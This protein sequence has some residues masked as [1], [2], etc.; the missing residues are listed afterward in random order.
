VNDSYLDRRRRLLV[1]L[2][3]G[4]PL[5]IPS[6]AGAMGNKPLNPTIYRLK[7]NAKVN[8]QPVSEATLIKL[9][10][11]I[12]TGDNSEMVFIVGKDAFLARGNTQV[13]TS[14]ANGVVKTLRLISGAV[15]SVHAPGEKQI[16]TPVATLGIRGTGVY[17]EA[18]DEKSYFCTCYGHTLIQSNDDP[19]ISKEIKTTHHDEPVWV[20]RR[21]EGVEITKAKMWNHTDAELEML[22][23]TVGREPPFEGH[24]GG[25]RY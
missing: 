2:L 6:I 1:Q 7:G 24:L 21:S 5:L 23:S 20:N 11:K 18:F 22:E 19:T 4:S 12:E 3:A 8:G 14:G 25:Y 13:E 16:V 10:D 17:T 9:G 15:L